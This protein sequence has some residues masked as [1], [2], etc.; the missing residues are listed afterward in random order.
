MHDWTLACI[1]QVLTVYLMQHLMLVGLM[2]P[3]SA[4]STSSTPWRHLDTA[5]VLVSAAG[6]GIATLADNALHSFVSS[7]G[8]HRCEVLREGLW[9][10]SRHPGHLGEQMWWWGAG[11][12]AVAAGQ[13][14]TLVGTAFN[15]LCMWKVPSLLTL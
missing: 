11:L 8:D 15:S 12:F 10:I 6:I 1:L 4:I 14:W 3:W 13:P 5:A 7:H 2:L 9:G